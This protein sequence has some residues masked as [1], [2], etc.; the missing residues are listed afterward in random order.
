MFRIHPLLIASIFLVLSITGE[1]KRIEVKLPELW[2]FDI[3]LVE[4]R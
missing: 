4:Y 2:S 3:V 1:G